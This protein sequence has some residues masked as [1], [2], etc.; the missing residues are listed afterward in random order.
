MDILKEADDC[1]MDALKYIKRL[2]VEVDFIENIYI[3]IIELW[4]TILQ[5]K[6][7]GKLEILKQKIKKIKDEEAKEKEN[8]LLDFNF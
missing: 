4:D 5:K 1:F 6:E 8:E 7:I 2:P 3:D